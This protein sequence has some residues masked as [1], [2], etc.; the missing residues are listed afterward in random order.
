[1][2]QIIEAAWESRAIKEEKT[3]VTI[4]IVVELLDKRGKLRVA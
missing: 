2:Q 4:H 1:M 3:H